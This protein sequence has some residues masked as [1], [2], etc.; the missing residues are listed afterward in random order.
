MIVNVIPECTQEFK[1]SFLLW[2]FSNVYPYIY[3][4][5]PVIVSNL[6]I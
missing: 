1:K 3:Y 5:V 6:P 4:S 2:D